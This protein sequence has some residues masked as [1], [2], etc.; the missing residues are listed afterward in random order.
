MKR[1]LHSAASFAAILVAGLSYGQSTTFSYTG[2]METYVVPAGVTELSIDCIGASG[3]TSNFGLPDFVPGDGGRVETI[4]TVTP[5]ATLYIY[6]GGEGTA[7]ATSVPG[8]GG[9]NGGADGNANGSNAGGGGGGASDIRIGGTALT[10]RVVVAGGGGGAGRN[11]TCCDNGGDGGDLI[12]NDGEANGA[13]GD[14]SC[15]TAG[16]QVAGGNG[17]QWSGYPL[18]ASGTLGNG[19]LGGATS[20]GGGGGGGYYGGGGGSWSGGGGGSSYTDAGLTTS[21]VHTK[22]HNTGDG[23][24]II[25]VLCNPISVVA[26]QDTVCSGEM[27]T[28]TGTSSGS[29]TISWDGGV[30]NGVAFAPGLGT[31]VYTATST[32]GNDCAFAQTI[33]VYDTPTVNAGVDQTVCQGELVTLTGSGANTYSWDGGITDGAAFV[34]AAG[35]TTYTLTGTIDSSGCQS[36][37]QVNITASSIDLTLT[38]TGTDLTC[39]QTGATYQWLLCPGMNV[40]AG[41]TGQTYQPTTA[42]N[43]ACA[44]TVGGCTDTTACGIVSVGLEKVTNELSL[45]IYPNPAKTE[46]NIVLQDVMAELIIY[47]STGQKVQEFP[48]FNGTKVIDLSDLPSGLYVLHFI[49][50]KGVQ[51]ERLMID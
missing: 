32:D 49:S 21:T 44:I 1:I 9:F 19:G 50:E 10:D 31:T 43:Y 6:V 18:A 25:T 4:L 17:G 29:G 27:V 23:T 40:I 38:E 37:D 36:T 12:G 48:S 28:L 51:T 41:E 13:T 16:T 30:S 46:V 42:G 5:G 24:I 35:T 15:G 45:S 7:A 3:G 14:V 33:F 34:P 8:V 20:S 47:S 22:G 39:V 26:T 11:Y 2:A